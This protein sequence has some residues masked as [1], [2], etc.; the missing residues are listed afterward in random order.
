MC[1]LFI[2][3]T[4]L[5][6]RSKNLLRRKD[7]KPYSFEREIAHL[8]SDDYYIYI[9]IY[10]YIICDDSYVIHLSIGYDYY[11]YIYIYIH[12]YTLYVMIVM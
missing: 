9:Y 7:H 2:N 1:C 8:I 5:Y 10:I 11:T 3:S 6:I 4:R 12:I